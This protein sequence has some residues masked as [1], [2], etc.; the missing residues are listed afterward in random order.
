MRPARRGRRLRRVA[1]LTLAA[2]VIAGTRLGAQSPTP[3]P[4]PAAA[5]QAPGDTGAQA[6]DRALLERQLRQRLAAVVRQRLQ[7]TDQQF[8]QLAAVNRK[9]ESQ[10]GS[11]LQQEV[12]LRTELRG[13]LLRGDQADQAHVNALLDQIMKVQQSR[14]AL[15]HDEQRELAGFLT[16]VQRA[17]FA[18]IQEQVRRRV[19]AM[20]REQAARRALRQQRQL[21]PRVRPRPVLPRGRRP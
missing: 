18:A 3:P 7:L 13:E 20:R 17:K 9:Y 6:A 11:L 16:P 15:G 12:G 21:A 19:N 10:R 4:P 14:L 5:A 8:A 1:A 2:V